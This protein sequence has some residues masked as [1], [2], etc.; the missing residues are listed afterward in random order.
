MK[1]LVS[2]IVIL[3]LLNLSVVSSQSGDEFDL[4]YDIE[5]NITM[6]VG[7]DIALDDNGDIYILEN[8]YVTGTC[9]AGGPLPEG[10]YC[11]RIKITKI[12]VET[13]TVV[14]TFHL[15][16]GTSADQGHAIAVDSSGSAYVVGLVLDASFSPTGIPV[17]NA[18]DPTVNS[19]IYNGYDAFL[20]KINPAGD[21]LVYSTFLGGSDHDDAN[22]VDVDDSGRA[23]VVG[24]TR[25]D[26]FPVLNAYQS[27]LNGTRFDAVITVIDTTQSGVTSLLYSSYLGGSAG[28]VGVAVDVD[29][30]GNVSVVG[31]AGSTDFPLVTAFQP[32]LAGNRDLFVA[33]MDTTVSGTSSLLYSTYLGGTESEAAWDIAV[34]GQGKVIVTGTTSS[35]NFPVVNA[36]QPVYLGGGEIPFT[37][38]GDG[39]VAK[40]D[41]EENELVY[42]SYLGGSDTETPRALTAHASG[43][44][45]VTGRTE[46]ND[47]T[48]RRALQSTYQSYG[49]AFI[50]AVHP[51]GRLLYSTYYSG[52]NT[53][54]SGI[55]IAVSQNGFVYIVGY[56]EEIPPPTPTP[57]GPFSTSSERGPITPQ[58][59][60]PNGFRVG[61]Q[62]SSHFPPSLVNNST[63]SVIN[64]TQLVLDNSLLRATDADTP[65]WGVLYS[66]TDSPD[67]GTLSSSRGFAQWDID[68]NTLVYNTPGTTDSF[69]ESFEFLISDGIS[70]VGP[71]TFTIDV[72]GESIQVSDQ[73]LLN[74]MHQVDP[75]IW[76]NLAILTEDTMEIYFE[77]DG[78]NGKSTITAG[79]G[80]GL[81]AFRCTTTINDVIPPHDEWVTWNARIM[82]IVRDALNTLVSDHYGAGYNVE[83]VDI[84]TNQMFI[85]VKA[86]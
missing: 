53:A 84:E 71:Y 17:Q 27:I 43:V 39:F 16:D 49:D 41:L 23:Y 80:H 18:F 46:S 48:I 33:Q 62:L 60:D 65:S 22:D 31:S 77:A 74:V 73:Q 32:A 59:S 5:A 12:D 57:V 44:V 85:G 13:N 79:Q 75:Q 34:D 70:A 26:D 42:S 52:T 14:Y 21:T 45:F 51:T 24:Q 10:R 78:V 69:S 30:N 28:E 1:T 9:I 67:Q 64:G 2:L 36:F 3:L 56:S 35:S 6:Q 58:N 50:T 4:E 76:V 55:G 47:F 7:H 37:T 15:T 66:V 38:P 8:E 86:P 63:V 72:V 20:S 40:L 61:L 19:T 82:D 11:L 29:S 54:D 83:V 68:T 81:V 25:S